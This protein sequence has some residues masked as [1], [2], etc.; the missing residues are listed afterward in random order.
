MNHSLLT[1]IC[2]T[3]LILLGNVQSSDAQSP[4]TR[5][6]LQTANPEGVLQSALES[7]KKLPDF[8]K[9]HAL[10]KNKQPLIWIITGDSITHG[11]KHTNGM[12]SYPEHWAELI[13]WD[14]KR[15]QDTVIN[16]GV[17]GDTMPRILK[18][19]KE[20]VASFSP[21]IVS[22]NMGMNDCAGGAENLSQYT[23]DLKTF[24]Q[25]VRQINAIPILQVPSVTLSGNGAREKNL[26]KY[27]QAVRDVAKEQKVLL[28]D[29]PTHFAQ[30]TNKDTLKTWMNDPIHPNGLGHAEMF[31]KMSWDLGFYS[32]K[33]PS[34]KLGEKTLP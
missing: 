20:R 29:H 19:W 11:A 32:N 25:K 4:A 23:N 24:V 10:V 12:R 1:S 16:T 27:A 13:R 9:L 14:K 26:P 18:Q 31:K 34:C 2:L 22:L 8:T 21:Q 28:V 7:N 15:T 3:S 5:R 30:F 33:F 17:S 6:T